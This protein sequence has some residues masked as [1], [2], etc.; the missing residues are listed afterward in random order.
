M[1]RDEFEPKW[2]ASSRLGPKIKERPQ[3]YNT[4]IVVGKYPYRCFIEMSQRLILR[5]RKPVWLLFVWLAECFKMG[6]GESLYGLR[7][8]K[9]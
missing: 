4:S 2:F 5:E 6:K 3:S 1:K 9:L 8:K 7:P